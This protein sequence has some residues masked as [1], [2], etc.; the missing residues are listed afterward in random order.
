MTIIN[1]KVWLPIYVYTCV[2][3]TQTNV[4]HMLKNMKKFLEINL[5]FK[6]IILKVFFLNLINSGLGLQRLSFILQNLTS[7]QVH[8]HHVSYK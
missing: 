4:D 7:L 2:Q 1:I 8:G 3:I 5:K 6:I